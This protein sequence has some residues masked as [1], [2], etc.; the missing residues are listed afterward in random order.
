M[1]GGVNAS[2]LQVQAIL[3]AWLHPGAAEGK[4][5]LRRSHASQN[6]TCSLFQR[7]LQADLWVLPGSASRGAA[8]GAAEEEEEEED[9]WLLKKR[10]QAQV[11]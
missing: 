9:K 3:E 8:G 5:N 2:L 4:E 6:Q 1:D 11:G 7:P 10:S